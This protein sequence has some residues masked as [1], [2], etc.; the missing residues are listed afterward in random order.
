MEKFISS[1]DLIVE[2]RAAIAAQVTAETAFGRTSPEY[3]A[4]SEF[5]HSFC[6]RI[7]AAE[8]KE[9]E[10]EEFNSYCEMCDTEFM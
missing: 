3:K 1:D 5:A 4:A 7:E 2:F 10:T 9:R 8:K 6:A